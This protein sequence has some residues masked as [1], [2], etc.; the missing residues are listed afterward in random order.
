MSFTVKFQVS[1]DM[2]QALSTE[3]SKVAI[4]RGNKTIGKNLAT[5]MVEG[6][7]K[8]PKTGRIYNFRG[9]KHQASSPG[10]YPANRSGDLARS[11][12]FVVRNAITLEVG[13]EDLDYAPILQQF[14]SPEDS[15]VNFTKIAPRPFISLAHRENEARFIPTMNNAW[16]QEMGL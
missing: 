9:R 14:T 16:L 12:N 15:S 10:E 1:K 13:S 3:K 2:K 6:I 5:S 4:L 7:R 11:I 8:G